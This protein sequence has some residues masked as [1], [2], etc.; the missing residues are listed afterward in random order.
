VKIIIIRPQPGADATAKRAKALGLEP[1]VMPLFAVTSTDWQAAEPGGYDALLITS[2]NAIRHGGAALVQ[3]QS[4]S[5]YA[6]GEQTAAVA[7]AAGFAVIATGDKDAAAL[8]AIAAKAGH[9][10]LLWLAGQ[11]HTSLVPPAGIKID[12]QIVYRSVALPAP[13]N[14]T[15]H[16][17]PPCCVMLHSARA[18]RYFSDLCL[19]NAVERQRISIAALSQNVADAAG[20]GW[21]QSAIAATPNDDAL[22]SAGLTCFT[23]HNRGP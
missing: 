7:R 4:L 11:N 12:T 3:M 5:V 14:F 21:R 18:A 15:D 22:L 13:S 8:L 2:A 16:L 10:H 9:N 17:T 19:E 6:V 1:A 23:N 20:L